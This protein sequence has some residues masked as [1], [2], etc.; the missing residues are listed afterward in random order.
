MNSSGIQYYIVVLVFYYL[1]PSLCVH[2]LLSLPFYGSYFFHIICCPKWCNIKFVF[3]IIIHK[4]FIA[5]S[6]GFELLIGII[7]AFFLRVI[8]CIIELRNT[9]KAKKKLFMIRVFCNLNVDLLKR[10][11]FPDDSIKVCCYH[12]ICTLFMVVRLT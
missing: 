3:Q 11:V 10:Q 2:K 8:F 1:N 6:I 7:F 5:F 12:N 9:K 4:V